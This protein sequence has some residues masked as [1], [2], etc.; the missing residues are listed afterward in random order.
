MQEF[1]QILTNFGFPIALSCYLLLRFEKIL[2]ALKDNIGSLVEVNED[3]VAKNTEL[4]TK[5]NEQLT[6][7]RLIKTNVKSLRSLLGRKR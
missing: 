4:L 2:T 6:E 7:I 3:L 5:N 1:L